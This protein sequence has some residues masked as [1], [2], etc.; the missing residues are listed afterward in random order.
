MLQTAY[1][2]E[3]DN[4]NWELIAASLLHDIGYLIDKLPENIADKSIDG[5]HEN[6]GAEFL[7]PHFTPKVVEPVRLHVAAKRYLC[8][9]E[10]DYVNTLTPASVKSLELQ[11]GPFNEREIKKFE[12]LPHFEDAVQL[13][14]YDERGK[15]PNVKT[16]NLKHYLQYIEAGLK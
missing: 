11:G 14:R 13:R 8:A 12:S 2:A 16:P 3:Q 10:P 5:R 1:L 9:I 15:I 4:E 7:A 6:G